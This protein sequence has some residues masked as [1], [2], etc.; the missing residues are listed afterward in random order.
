MKLLVVFL[1]SMGL[2]LTIDAERRVAYELIT[3]LEGTILQ[4]G[5]KEGADYI[6]FIVPEHYS[7]DLVKLIISNSIK[8]KSNIRVVN[9]WRFNEDQKLILG[10]LVNG[11]PFFIQYDMK[12][13]SLLIFYKN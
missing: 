5:E 8:G 12:E 4:E 6:F 3:D 1:I 10:L 9:P 11:N 2:L 13:N 7:D